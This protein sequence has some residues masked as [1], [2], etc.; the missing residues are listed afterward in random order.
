[1][2]KIF[3]RT[4]MIKN[5]FLISLS[6]LL[7][8]CF[9]PVLEGMRSYYEDAEQITYFNDKYYSRKKEKKIIRKNEDKLLGKSNKY[10]IKNN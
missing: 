2:L 4:P 10:Y 3:P 9:Y 7:S 5:L 6:F 1:M 8:S